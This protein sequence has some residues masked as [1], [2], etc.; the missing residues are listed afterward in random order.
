MRSTFFTY[1]PLSPLLMN[2]MIHAVMFLKW[3]HQHIDSQEI[4]CKKYFM[5][6]LVIIIPTCECTCSLNEYVYVCCACLCKRV[7]CIYVHMSAVSHYGSSFVYLFLAC[8]W[9]FL[10]RLVCVCVC[11]CVREHISV[12]MHVFIECFLSRCRIATYLVSR[13]LRM[14]WSTL[15]HMSVLQILSSGWV[16]F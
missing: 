4:T 8:S 5:Q 12:G 6:Q 11:V 1:F 7:M 2:H 3:Q 16:N 15:T 10:F 9:S 13:S 14:F